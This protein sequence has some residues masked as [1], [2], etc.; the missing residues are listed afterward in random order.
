MTPRERCRERIH[1]AIAA[2]EDDE[3]RGYLEAARKELD[4]IGPT[5]LVECPVCERVGLPERI[6]AHDC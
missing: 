2:T 4:A 3:V 1:D 6:V 5:P